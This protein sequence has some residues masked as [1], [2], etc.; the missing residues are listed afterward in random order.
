MWQRLKRLFRKEED[1]PSYLQITREAQWREAELRSQL[2]K[3][4]RDVQAMTTL[5]STKYK[6][7]EPKFVY[8][9]LP[10]LIA[11]WIGGAPEEIATYF[12]D[13]LTSMFRQE[14]ALQV[15]I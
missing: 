4:S 13:T 5:R 15:A 7:H 14:L 8:V 3:L 1:R 9:E 11:R 2:N 12:L 6:T 10:N